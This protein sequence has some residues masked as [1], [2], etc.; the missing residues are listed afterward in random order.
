MSKLWQHQR[1]PVPFY[2]ALAKGILKG[3]QLHH[4][5]HGLLL[6]SAHCDCLA[7]LREACSHIA[8]VLFALEVNTQVKKKHL[9]HIHALYLDSPSCQSITYAPIAKID[10]K[11]KRKSSDS[12][13]VKEE[14]I[15]KP[16]EE[17]LQTLYRDLPA[18]GKPFCR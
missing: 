7:G 14:E 5:S 3:S 4:L 10:F 2:C 12:S 16:T 6:N 15:P 8:A 11:Q 18:A 9:L 1:V 13:L 17:E